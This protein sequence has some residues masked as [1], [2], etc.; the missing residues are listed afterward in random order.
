MEVIM[1]KI[2]TNFDK[3]N[4]GIVLVLIV[5][6]LSLYGFTVSSFLASGPSQGFSREV[7]IL[8]ATSGK[9]INLNSHVETILL[10]EEKV[11]IAAVDDH[12]YKLITISPLGTVLDENTLDLDLFNARD[13]SVS[14]D[15]EGILTLYY[16]VGDL[17]KVLIDL[18]TMAYT[19]SIVSNDVDYFT[20]EDQ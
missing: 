17:F 1:K 14:M 2:R 8:K 4:K 11:L 9:Q 16:I 5:F 12:H 6:L 19:Q 10:S 13:I 15:Q 20:R 18:E 3:S 7:E